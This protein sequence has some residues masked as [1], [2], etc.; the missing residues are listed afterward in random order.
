M[1]D[2][3]NEPAAKQAITYALNTDDRTVLEFQRTEAGE[4]RILDITDHVDAL[5]QKL[6]DG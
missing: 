6:D 1:T 4:V 2:P 5:E 3:E